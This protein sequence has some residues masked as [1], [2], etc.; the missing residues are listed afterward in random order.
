[1]LG[2]TIYLVYYEDHSGHG[3]STGLCSTEFYTLA[4]AITEAQSLNQNG[5]KGIVVYESKI[6]AIHGWRKK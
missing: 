2:E 1:M 3:C 5:Y 4:A 6:T